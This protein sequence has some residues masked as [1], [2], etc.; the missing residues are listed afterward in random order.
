MAD[1]KEEK[2]HRVNWNL[3]I[4]AAIILAAFGAFGSRVEI[5]VPIIAILAGTV[6]IVAPFWFWHKRKLAREG[7]DQK[8]QIAASNPET[9]SQMKRMQERVEN[10]EA[11]MC[12]LD[13][14][15][16]LQMEK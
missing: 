7:L 12:N 5:M 15:I 9:E 1:K 16:N 8:T 13:R 4:Y 6:M 11:M 10:L 3:L 2:S 14:E